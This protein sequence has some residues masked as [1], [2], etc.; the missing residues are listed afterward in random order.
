M[1]EYELMRRM[2]KKVSLTESSKFLEYNTYQINE[3]KE[4]LSDLEPKWIDEFEEKYQLLIKDNLH[5]TEL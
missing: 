5:I 4:S 3:I 2:L 1:L